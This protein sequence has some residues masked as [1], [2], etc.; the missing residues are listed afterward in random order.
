MVKNIKNIT[1]ESGLFPILAKGEFSRELVK[2]PN[3][4]YHQLSQHT[5]KGELLKLFDV[6]FPKIDVT[7]SV[8]STPF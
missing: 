8:N 3:E 4:C 5:L 1:C 6:F 7:I 2:A